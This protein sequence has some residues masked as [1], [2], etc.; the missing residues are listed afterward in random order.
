MARAS[1][2]KVAEA[3]STS[4]ASGTIAAVLVWNTTTATTTDAALSA[5]RPSSG[6]DWARATA[7]DATG[8]IE[9]RVIGGEIQAQGGDEGREPQDQPDDHRDQPAVSVLAVLHRAGQHD[10]LADDGGQRLLLLVGVRRALRGPAGQP[11][12]QLLSAVVGLAGAGRERAAPRR[13]RGAG[14]GG[15]AGAAGEL[16]RSAVEPRGALAS[17]AVPCTRLFVLALSRPLGVTEGVGRGGHAGRASRQSP[18]A[19]GEPV[20]R[21]SRPSPPRPCSPAEPPR[22]AWRCA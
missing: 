21:R 22:P 19:V 1:T 7:R 5:A 2:A 17:E 8:A 20:T 3:S 11:T 12:A 6:R 10:G 13:E 9:F 4:S 15:G 14:L 18:G 16:P